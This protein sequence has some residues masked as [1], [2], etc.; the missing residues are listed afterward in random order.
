MSNSRS[1]SSDGESLPDD[2]FHDDSSTGGGGGASVAQAPP[3]SSQSPPPKPPRVGGGSHGIASFINKNSKKI[4]EISKRTSSDSEME[5]SLKESSKS[6][7]DSKGGGG[8]RWSFKGGK[9]KRQQSVPVDVNLAGSKKVESQIQTENVSPTRLT[10]N[11]GGLISSMSI[12]PQDDSASA[13]TTPSNSGP[14]PRPPATSSTHSSALDLETV[15]EG[16]ESSNPS[17]PAPKKPSRSTNRQISSGTGSESK[18]SPKPRQKQQQ[19]RTKLYSDSQVLADD[20]KARSLEGGSDLDSKKPGINTLERDNML[21]REQVKL[22][23]G[24]NKKLKKENKDFRTKLK[25]SGEWDLPTSPSSHSESVTP[26]PRDSA[27]NSEV[28]SRVPSESPSHKLLAYSELASVSSKADQEETNLK[29]EGELSLERQDNVS[30]KSEGDGAETD[31]A[32][33]ESDERLDGDDVDTND[34]GKDVP[35]SLPSVSGC[36]GRGA[37]TYLQGGFRSSSVPSMSAPDR[38]KPTPIPRSGT[39]SVGGSRDVVKASRDNTT[40]GFALKGKSMDLESVPD[41]VQTVKLGSFVTKPDNPVPKPRAATSPS[42]FCEDGEGQKLQ[43]DRESEV[44]EKEKIIARKTLES[45]LPHIQKQQLLGKPTPIPRSMSAREVEVNRK[46]PLTPRAA[47]TSPVRTV[48]T[49]TLGMGMGLKSPP[50]AED[51]PVEEVITE[52][53][54]TAAE[55]D[56]DAEMDGD[57]GESESVE[58]DSDTVKGGITSS[59]GHVSNSDVRTIGES[60]RDTNSEIEED[61]RTASMLSNKSFTSSITL[62][63]SSVAKE[64]SSPITKP[65]PPTPSAVSKPPPPA[66]ALSATKPLPLTPPSS[67]KPLPSTPPTTTKSL[68]SSTTKPLPPPPYGSTKPLPPTPSSTSKPLPPAPIKVGVSSTSVPTSMSS[69]PASAGI[70]DLTGSISPRTPT[71]RGV[72][73]GYKKVTIQSDTSWINKRKAAEKESTDSANSVTIKT[74]GTASNT[75]Q[76]GGVGGSVTSPTTGSQSPGSARAHAPY[77]SHAIL[78][79][80]SPTTAKTFLSPGTNYGGS[81]GAS[82]LKPTG[83]CHKHT[84][85]SI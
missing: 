28:S 63:T 83:E 53:E 73:T 72:G 41:T 1:Q 81:S 61:E 30:S 67:T 84:K 42:K 35:G 46:L 64:A 58:T 60:S 4:R 47:S 65:L 32:R 6:T 71:A 70:K 26:S 74:T 8:R 17:S 56:R 3:T 25:D 13:E 16:V 23:K 19:H 80:P 18:P 68:P 22:L 38:P 49:V 9:G 57:P 31:K 52:K 51:E 45:L 37:V 12:S 15:H 76:T 5:D 11:E 34:E 33:L 59:E 27:Q 77:R 62:S 69:P 10:S 44:K 55:R 66:T 82:E 85:F 24:Q 48:G 78:P 54:P 40:H 50:I 43:T 20:S 39:V 7:S 36:V 29:L 75:G 14:H 2:V 21:L 79:A